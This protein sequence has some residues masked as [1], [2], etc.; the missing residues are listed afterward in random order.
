MDGW[1]F[2]SANCILVQLGATVNIYPNADLGFFNE[3]KKGPF[4]VHIITAKVPLLGFK[5]DLRKEIAKFF[6]L[7]NLLRP[8]NA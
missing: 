5:E 8:C 3:A 4:L 1:M 2:N 6:Q 7:Q